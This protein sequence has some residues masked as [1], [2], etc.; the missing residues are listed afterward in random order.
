MKNYA[1]INRIF[2]KR[3]DENIIKCKNVV[4]ER[5]KANDNTL[6]VYIKRIRGKLG[7]DCV[8]KTVK[9]IGYMVE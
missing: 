6:T 2:N 9:G 5:D 4:L 8:I 3:E 7:D 1:R